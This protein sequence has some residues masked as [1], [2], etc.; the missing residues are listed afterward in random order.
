MHDFKKFPN[1]QNSRLGKCRNSNNGDQRTPK[2][3]K[4]KGGGGICESLVKW[5]FVMFKVGIFSQLFN[6]QRY[7][8]F[9]LQNGFEN[10]RES[11]KISPNLS[12]SLISHVAGSYVAHIGHKC[13]IPRYLQRFSLVMVV[14]PAIIV[15]A[16]Q[17]FIQIGYLCQPNAQHY[18]NNTHDSFK[19]YFTIKN[20][21]M[22]SYKYD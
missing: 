2:K 17:S 6:F 12:L 4:K 19:K 3:K 11:S 10:V 9:Q 8:I 22:H 14:T 16:P 20:S 15:A 7:W 13:S 18:I 21:I 5:S 1:F